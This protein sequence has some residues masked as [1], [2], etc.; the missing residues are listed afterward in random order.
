MK[1]LWFVLKVLAVAGAAFVALV[2][3]GLLPQVPDSIVI[4]V[5]LAVG[6]GVGLLQKRAEFQELARDF[7]DLFALYQ[8][9]AI[10]PEQFQTKLKE[11]VEDVQ[12]I[13]SAAPLI[14]DRV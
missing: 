13:W 10:N 12:S 2:D 5:A 4:T 11:V 8:T 9:G 1:K 14:R 6:V 7:M 3:T